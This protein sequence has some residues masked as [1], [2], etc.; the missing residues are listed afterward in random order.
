MSS[1]LIPLSPTQQQFDITLGNKRYSMRFLYNK[2]LGTWTFDL[3][4]ENR[5]P[6]VMGTPLVTGYNLLEQYIYLGIPG[7][8]VV[9]TDGDMDK[10]PTIDGLGKETNLYYVEYSS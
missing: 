4:D 3:Y 2:I 8:L 1:F 10:L 5:E 9:I 6:L 7:R